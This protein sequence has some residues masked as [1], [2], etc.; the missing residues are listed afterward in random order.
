MK[1]TGLKSS[2][3]Y[4]LRVSDYL[5]DWR[6]EVSRPQ[7]AVKAF[8]YPYWRTHITLEEVRIPGSRLRI[9]LMN[10]TRRIVIEVFPSSTHSFNKFFHGSKLA[11]GAAVRRD[12]DK[13]AWAERNGFQ[14]IELNDD[15]IAALSPRLFADRGITL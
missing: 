1:V 13:Q 10:L 3:P 14:Y 6:R 12:L 11:F 4:S 7:A 9:D 8:L 15:D 2:R 5:V